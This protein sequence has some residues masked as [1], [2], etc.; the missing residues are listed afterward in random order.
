MY[1]NIF[2]KVNKK[3]RPNHCLP[4][5]RGGMENIFTSIFN[6]AIAQNKFDQFFKAEVAFSEQDSFLFPDTKII[7]ILR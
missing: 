7:R 1:K 5:D 2:Y 4:R 3:F 6:L